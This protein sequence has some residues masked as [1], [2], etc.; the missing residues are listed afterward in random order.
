MKASCV[1]TFIG[2][3]CYNT[4][5]CFSQDDKY[6]AF[7]TFTFKIL[8]IDVKTYEYFRSLQ[9]HD[10][11]ISDF[12]FSPNNKYLA[13][14][15]FD[16][17]TKLWDIDTGDCIHT[18]EDFELGVMAVCFSADGRYLATASYDMK[19][20]L[21]DI[22]KGE[23][24]KTFEIEIISHHVCNLTFSPDGKYLLLSS[25]SYDNTIRLWN[26]LTGEC[27]KFIVGS[28]FWSATFSPDSKYFA[29]SN[30]DL[31]IKIWNIETKECIKVFEG[32]QAMGKSLC[33]SR[34]GKYLV[35][36]ARSDIIFL[37]I[38]T[39]KRIILRE[40]ITAETISI[41]QDGR[42]LAAGLFALP[43]ITKIWSI[44]DTDSLAARLLLFDK[45]TSETL[46][47][48]LIRELAAF[49]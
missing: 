31:S 20:K 23:C 43:D 9:H 6:L 4:K 2:E 49:I 41:S 37:N 44:E 26:V 46:P 40:P 30:D 5:I 12:S 1:K 3:Q 47:E 14:A 16:C 33:F 39:G 21:W 35:Y 7:E 17:T 8:L 22:A 42:Y 32:Q 25:G 27:Y 45:A 11:V 29:S 34:D 10:D 15:S 24:L 19:V 48:D 36:G 18:F 38:I 13:S 28:K